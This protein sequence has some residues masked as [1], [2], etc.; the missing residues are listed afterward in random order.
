MANIFSVL[1]G[2]RYRQCQSGGEFKNFKSNKEI[3]EYFRE[4]FQ[5]LIKTS[6][7]DNA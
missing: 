2:S 3:L 5:V 7:H 1:N 4:D 6:I